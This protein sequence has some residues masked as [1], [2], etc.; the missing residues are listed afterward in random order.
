MPPLPRHTV[1]DIALDEAVRLRC[2]CRVRT[3]TR[4]ELVA[5]VGRDARLGMI[6]L[7]P[8]LRCDDCGE[9]SFEGWTVRLGR[10]AP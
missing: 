9:P 6:G 1:A 3:F 4:A 8:E 7:R 10:V 5:R 2:A